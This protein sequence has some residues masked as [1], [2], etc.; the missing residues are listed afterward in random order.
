MEIITETADMAAWSAAQRLTGKVV[1]FVPTMGALHEGHM[2]LVRQA[3]DRCDAVVASVFVNPLQ[4]NNPED[5]AKYPRQLEADKALLATNGCHALFAPDSAGIYA[6]HQPRD[7]PLG[8]LDQVLEGPSRPG[9]F[10]GVVNVV[11][12][13][14]HYVRPDLAFFGEKDRQQLAVITHVAGQQHW[15]ERI[16]GCPTERADDG[17]ALSSRNARLNAEQRTVAPVLYK[18]LRTAAQTAFVHSVEDS[19]RAALTVLAQEPE[20]RL[21]YLEIAH[22]VSLRPLTDWGELQEVSVLIAA[23]LGS[24]RL[25]DNLTVVR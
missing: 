4:F 2:A 24:V 22:P 9:H 3:L 20:V 13:L 16:I 21:D 12:R 15:P 18:S 8:G 5:L 25:I 6:G 10:N 19:K 17:L 11:E 14:F 1:G 23:W 7:F